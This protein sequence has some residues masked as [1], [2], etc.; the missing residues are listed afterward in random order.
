MTKRLVFLMF[1]LMMAS[2][3]L[4]SC[5]SDKDN[6]KNNDDTQPSFETVDPSQAIDLK[7]YVMIRSDS[8]SKE[9]KD[10]A[11]DLRMA[12][13]KQ[14]GFL[15]D[16]K[17][18]FTGKGDLE[19]VIGK[20]KRGGVDGLNKAQYMIKHT[21]K[22]FLIAGGSDEATIA[23]LKF[24]EENLLSPSGVLCASDFEYKVD[25]SVKIG[26][27]TYDEIK[28]FVGFILE[29]CSETVI[30]SF[31]LVG[32]PASVCDD[33]S[34]ANIVLTADADIKVNTIPKGNWG[35]SA[36]NGILYIVGRNDYDVSSV[37]SYVSEY[38][39]SNKGKFSF[40][41]G[42][43]KMDKNPSKEEFYEQKNLTV[44]PEFPERIRRDY[45]YSVSVTQGD[46]TATLPVYNHCQ[47][48]IAYSRD[49]IGGDNWR[50]F[51]MFAFSGEQVRI[52]VKVGCDFENYCVIPSAKEIKS[53]FKNGVISIYLDKPEYIV[54]RLDDD[55]NTALSILADYPEYPL[56]IP[57]KD[58]PNVT[59]ISG[60]VEPEDGFTIL[61]KEEQILYI[62]PGA[63][64]FSRVK[65]DA[66]YC[67]VLGRGAI[68]DPFENFYKFN[69]AGQT[70]SK[71]VKL[72]QMVAPNG[73]FD[74]PVLLDAHCY[75]FNVKKNCVVRNAKALSVMITSDGLQLHSG[76][77]AER[78][79]MYVGDNGTVYSG[80][81]VQYKD[82]TIGTTCA[83]IFPQ[84]GTK[85]CKME[86]IYVFRSDGGLI[87]NRY[88]GS[89]ETP[90]EQE[91]S[92]DI[93][94]LYADDCTCLP[95]FFQG[96]NM[97]R[98]DK[99]F[100]IVNATSCGTRGVE[101][102]Y[103]TH[104]GTFIRFDTTEGKIFT[105]NYTLN[106]KNLYIG[107]QLIK[108]TDDINVKESGQ[109]MGPKNV[110]NLEYDDTKVVARKNI[111]VGYKNSL[112]VYIGAL[113]VFLDNPAISEGDKI[114][115]PADEIRTLLRA[116]GDIKTVDKNGV[117]Y[118]ETK[119][120][121]SAKMAEDCEIA[122]NCV[123][124]TPVY[125]G[126]NLLLPDTGDIPYYIEAIA[127]MVD[128]TAENTDGETVYSLFNA[129]KNGSGLSRDLTD[130]VKMYG[131]GTYV[132]EFEIR[133]N[134]TARARNSLYTSDDTS[135]K[136]YPINLSGGWQTVRVEMDVDFD[137]ND[138]ESYS[139]SI[140]TNDDSTSTFDVKN[141]TVTKIS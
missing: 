54:L 92:V 70:E 44:Y 61:D 31:K 87:N 138:F 118:V 128:M 60:V 63:V 94:G 9:V 114:Y 16:L 81:N 67:K 90:N 85:N 11:V 3:L 17:T 19:I 95:W 30:S 89:S 56:D 113:Q 12:I 86:D 93:I 65:L 14:C 74:G 59:W 91:H 108:T 51:S 57:S 137:L 129:A 115:L 84:G 107:G 25:N 82:I 18:D 40:K 68:V 1:A 58:D 135:S 111:E 5:S 15:P 71:G 13:Q 48:G 120:L 29:N 101:S 69:P 140:T 141:I 8:S 80:D 7:D 33:E 43:L 22:G 117:K 45:M 133:G 64:L 50:R 62:E 134:G 88:N 28:I 112:N 21:E 103:N 2:I 77:L 55:N 99:V 83:A 96:Q 23:A 72:M 37:C 127:Y 136:S 126:E 110:I 24:F 52:D 35:V 20:T 46:K 41:D 97:G 49:N 66:E 32:V 105:D 76:S 130:E 6:G 102:H 106:F 38:F 139:F 100:N 131:N 132:L 53:E 73:L 122:G 119:E 34:K 26:D 42:V 39:S 36:Q 98:L 123:V 109:G 4:C 27:K 121:V 125:N 75:N 79:F 10:A 104:D 47:P 78:C 116:K 124:L